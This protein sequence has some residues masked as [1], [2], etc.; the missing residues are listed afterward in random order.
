MLAN[1][2][3]RKDNKLLECWYTFKRSLF[4]RKIYCTSFLGAI[5]LSTIR[6]FSQVWP[7][8]RI[9]L[10]S[11]N[12]WFISAFPKAGD[13]IL[14]LVPKY[15]WFWT[16]IYQSLSLP[17]FLMAFS[18]FQFPMHNYAVQNKHWLPFWCPFCFLLANL[19]SFVTEVI[20]QHISCLIDKGTCLTSVLVKW[21]EDCNKQCHCV[22]YIVGC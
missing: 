18:N 2:Y 20:F 5:I 22:I 3:A 16:L 13:L 12:K 21:K 17:A 9:Y 1:T 19:Q 15:R 7:I 11:L 10:G 8:F 4:W 6:F 14:N